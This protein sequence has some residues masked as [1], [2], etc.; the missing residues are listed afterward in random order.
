MASS[1]NQSFVPLLIAQVCAAL[2]VFLLVMFWPGEWNIERWVGAIIAIPSMVLLLTARFQLGRSFS[3]S[4][5]ARTLVT[6]GLYS[7]IRNPMY[8]FSALLVLGF[9]FTLQNPFLFV[10]LAVLVPTQ[11]IRAHQEGKVLEAKFGEE[12]REYRKK[13]WF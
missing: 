11:I 7:K 9:L 2:L 13:T 10:I 5:Q 6:R 8:V 12:Y 4:P 1:G 3:V